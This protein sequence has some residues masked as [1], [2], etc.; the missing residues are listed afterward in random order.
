[1]RHSVITLNTVMGR[2]YTSMEE[3]VLSDELEY[4]FMFRVYLQVYRSLISNL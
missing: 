4:Q 1:M 3:K 2:K